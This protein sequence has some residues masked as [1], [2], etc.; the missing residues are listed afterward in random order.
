MNLTSYFTLEVPKYQKF[1]FVSFLLIASFH[2]VG[3]KPKFWTSKFT[4]FEV[5]RRN[6]K[7]N[8]K[9]AF[10]IRKK[11]VLFTAIWE[12]ISAVQ[13]WFCALEIFVSSADHILISAVNGFSGHEQRWL[14]TETFLNQTSSALKVSET[15]TRDHY[16]VIWCV[17]NSD[18]VNE[19]N[20]SV[21]NGYFWNFTKPLYYSAELPLTLT[22]F[23]WVTSPT[24]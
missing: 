20:S 8:W 12:K 24:K 11:S 9:I 21:L 10:W 4:Y 5:F 19:L 14:I 13:S 7:L 2:Y 6:W 18:V 1:G 17:R 16:L 22:S 23:E 3:W 15:S